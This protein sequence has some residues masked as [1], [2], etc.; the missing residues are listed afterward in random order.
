MRGGDQFLWV[1]YPY[2]VLTVFVGGHLYR[3]HTHPYSWTSRSSELLEKRWLRWGSPLFHWGILAVFLG[4]V[5]GLLVPKSVHEA[6][7]LSDTVYHFLAVTVG[8]VAGLVTA[9]GAIILLIRRVGVPRVRHTSRTGDFVAIVLVCLV[10]LSG[11]WATLWN[12]LGHTA[13]DYRE[14]I[15]PWLRGVLT[16]QPDPSLMATVPLPFKVHVLAAFSLFAV[17]PFTRLVHVF[18]LP[19][20][21]LWRSYVL[22]R[23]RHVKAVTKP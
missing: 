15:G 10:I 14:T 2:I 5:G 21:Y 17:W 9:I 6:L 7:G 8:G 22:Y 20:A 1:I 11:M 23:R 4:H 16:F 18:S 3:I 12:S 13:F 19:L